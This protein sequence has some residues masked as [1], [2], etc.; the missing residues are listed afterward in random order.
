MCDVGTVVCSKR[1]LLVNLWNAWHPTWICYT[2]GWY[3]RGGPLWIY[4]SPGFV[5][6]ENPIEL[7][8]ASLSNPQGDQYQCDG[9]PQDQSGDTILFV[10][11]NNPNESYDKV[12]LLM[13]HKV[14]YC[15]LIFH[16]ASGNVELKLIFTSTIIWHK[17]YPIS[18]WAGL[19]NTPWKLSSVNRIPLRQIHPRMNAYF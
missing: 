2:T 5:T 16:T 9:L 12:T 3:W 14:A 15:C 10:A 19:F 11:K 4:G 6:G 8:K 17:L 7:Y 1:N 13:A 18:E